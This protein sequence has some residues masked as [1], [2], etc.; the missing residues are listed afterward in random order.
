MEYDVSICISDPINASESQSDLVT[1]NNSA[2]TSKK[3][4]V[5]CFMF[6]IR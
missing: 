6:Y 4:F 5:L 3:M 1:D 2:A